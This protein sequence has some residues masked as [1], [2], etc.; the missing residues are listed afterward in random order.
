MVDSV[1]YPSVSLAGSIGAL[2]YLGLEPACLGFSLRC[3]SSFPCWT[4]LFPFVNI[5]KKVADFDW[6]NLADRA[7]FG[8]CWRIWA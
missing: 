6:E 1:G 7:D 8:N 5:G 3:P 2:S 4:S